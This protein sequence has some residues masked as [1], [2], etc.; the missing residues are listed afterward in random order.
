MAENQFPPVH[1]SDI[2]LYED[3]T[4]IIREV[5][6]DFMAEISLIIPPS[7]YPSRLGYHK[8]AKHPLSGI[9]DLRGVL[10]A[11][12]HEVQVLDC[13]TKA[14]PY[15]YMADNIN[16]DADIVGFTTLY[17][18]FTF[19]NKA[20]NILRETAKNALFVTGGPSASGAPEPF[21][22]NAGIDVV[23]RG[24]GEFALRMLAQKGKAFQDIPGICFLADNGMFL[25]TKG[26]RII[27]NLNV[28]PEIDWAYTDT[29]DRQEIEFIYLVGRGCNNGC[30]YC[31]AG[32]KLR[33]KSP[34]RVKN[35]LLY[36]RTDFDATDLIITDSD[37]FAQNHDLNKYL[38]VFRDLGLKWGCFTTPQNLTPAFLKNLSKAG[39]VN[40]RVGV[41]SFDDETLARNR[42]H[43]SVP[44]LYKSLA[45]LEESS[46][47][48]ITTCLL[49][50]LPGQTDRALDKTLEE[51][52]RHPRFI[53]R[54]FYL[55]P[56][57]GS[58]I[59]KDAFNQGIIPDTTVYLNRLKDVPI[60][61]YTDL[62]P[63]LSDASPQSMDATLEALY[64]IAL[65]RSAMHEYA[66]HV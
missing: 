64:K 16:V 29:W 37:L 27:D 12:G 35:E 4:G 30:A 33:R 3:S 44:E 13:R 23:V 14:D 47:E 20:V 15:G 7:R 26:R 36:L 58:K 10:L 1:F 63:N 55:L 22:R 46:I 48:K 11:D 52:E 45:A 28:L 65:N 43:I 34:K 42:P 50:G 59:F 25:Q 38:D 5:R 39:C 9:T 32:A 53:P 40:I 24:E 49:I 2:L 17:D 19:I 66:I 31:L 21:L 62:L 6:L 54:P 41:E 56:L 57:P 8:Y 60:D 51:I 18:S 61:R